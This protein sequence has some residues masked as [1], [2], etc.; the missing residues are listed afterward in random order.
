M[1]NGSAQASRRQARSARA[2]GQLPYAESDIGAAI[3][4]YRPDLYRRALEPLGAKLPA[5][6]AKADRFFDV[7]VFDPR[8]DLAYRHRLSS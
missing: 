1:H 6:D 8:T 7:E 5:L 2:R 3:G 4:T